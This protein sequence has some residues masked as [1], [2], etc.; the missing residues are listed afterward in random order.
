MN[1]RISQRKLLSTF[2]LAFCMVA[3]GAAKGQ[4]KAQLSLAE[5]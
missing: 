5:M 1:Q 2:F 3:M 4:G